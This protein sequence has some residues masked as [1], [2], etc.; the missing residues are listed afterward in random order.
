MRS[1]VILL[2]TAACVHSLVLPPTHAVHERREIHSAQWARRNRLSAE[3][4]LPMRVGLTQS[5]LDK[6]HDS[7]MEL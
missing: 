1:L 6:G 7:L 5:N 4:V 2:S 3:V